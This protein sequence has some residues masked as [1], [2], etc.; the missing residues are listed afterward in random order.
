MIN[1]YNLI[2]MK[3]NW[4][5]EDKEVVVMLWIDKISYEF[6]Y[7]MLIFGSYKILIM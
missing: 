4:K 6:K 5:Y 2:Y 7:F 3:S 1:Y